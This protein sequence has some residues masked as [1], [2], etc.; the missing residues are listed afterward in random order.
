MIISE[1]WLR[2]WVPTGIDSDELMQK[3]TLLG[4]EVGS[5]EKAGASLNGV[6]VGEI[7]DITPHPDADRLRVCEVATGG[8][9]KKLRIVCGASNAAV[10]LKVAVA[11]IGSELP[12]GLKISKSKIRG[13]ESEGMLCSAAELGLA[14]DS[15]GI[16]E[17]DPT[18]V[19]GLRFNEFFDLDDNIIEI[20]LTPNRGDCMSL[21]GIARE[22]ATVTRTKVREPVV[23]TI[24]AV[25]A[26]KVSV[27]LKS[28]ASCPRFVCRV[29]SN[30]DQQA[31]TPAWMVERLRRC[32]LRSISPIVDVTNY[33]MIE[34]GQ[35]MHAF[36]FDKLENTIVVRKARAKEKLT[37]LD[38]TEV[39]LGD[40]HL[41][42]ADKNKAIALA[43]IMG[44]DATAISDTTTSIL[45]EAAHFSPQAIIG[46]GRSLG[47]HTDAA[48]RF[49]RGVDPA[50]QKKAIQRATA[51][52]LEIVGGEP[53]PVVEK[54]E[55]KALPKKKSTRLRRARLEKM[56]G[57]G[58]PDKRVA[59][60][61]ARL[62]MKA[63]ASSTGWR[64]TPP[65][66]RFDVNHEHDLIE[67]VARVVGYDTV[68]AVMPRVT[69]TD[70]IR[71]E[72]IISR[73]RIDHSL[74][75]RDY[76]EVVTYSFVDPGVQNTL[77]PDVK[78]IKLANPI[79][80]NMSDMRVSLLP[81]LVQALTGNLNRQHRRVRLYEVGVV[82]GGTLKKR[83]ETNRLA[84]VVT[85]DAL[86]QHWSST[87]EPV[88]FFDI[89]GDLESVLNLVSRDSHD[90]FS[91]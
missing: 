16:L 2:E 48:Q 54:V 5:V 46:R 62:G 36:D 45:L 88:D 77:F 50:I 66:W 85:G 29:I 60:V 47:L 91:F 75:A 39:V 10:G 19:N 40:E 84:A 83:I 17:L 26:D 49:E 21:A 87:P 11:K 69:A 15:A 44:G 14:E 13:V 31:T 55:T 67:E 74:M 64:V 25:N 57:R 6:F 79:A 34:L 33:V 51:L 4:L 35:P 23:D 42:I 56:I 78:A 71:D 89:K 90:N 76:R 7:T 52:L 58:Y 80:S 12:V 24:K 18:A 70:F 72:R 9:P 86:S 59:D 8:K 28:T 30:I 22:L 68:E 43:G 38:K 53:G 41:V 37:L 61:L 81:G 20:D 73:D 65:G 82:F 27:Q 32:G 3:L 63:T 1:S